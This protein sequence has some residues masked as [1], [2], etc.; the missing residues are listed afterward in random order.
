M[1]KVRS[2]DR[3]AEAL[4]AHGMGGR[5]RELP[6]STRTAAEAGAAL[7]CEVGQIV[8]SLVFRVP[9][10]DAALLVLASGSTRVDVGKLSAIV[11]EPVEQ[12][13]GAFVRERTGFAIGGVAPVGL[14]APVTTYIERGVLAWDRFW[15]AA[16]SPRTVF[17]ATPDELIAA[18]GGDVVDVAE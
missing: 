8:K 13:S 15:A 7:G 6:E 2:V 10:T 12:A 3:V 18:T 4:V 11:G 1:A 16:G 9:T 5:S 17:D 14:V